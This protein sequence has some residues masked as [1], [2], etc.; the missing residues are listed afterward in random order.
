MRGSLDKAC[1]TL[2]EL[3]RELE[4]AWAAQASTCFLVEGPLIT[5]LS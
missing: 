3:R 1:H 2:H 4:A 5:E